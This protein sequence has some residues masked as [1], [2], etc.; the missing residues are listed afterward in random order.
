M[1]MLWFKRQQKLK[2]LTQGDIAAEFGR[3]RTI[4][5]RL[6]KGRQRFTIEHAMV[7]AK[8]L[9]QPLALILEK[10]GSPMPEAAAAIDPKLR[11]ADAEPWRPTRLADQDRLERLRNLSAPDGKSVEIW[12]VKTT[13]M[14]IAGM[15]PGDLLA[16]VEPNAIGFRSGNTVIAEAFD[17]P[18]GTTRVVLRRYDRPIL[19]PASPDQENSKCYLVDDINVRIIGLISA[20][21]RSY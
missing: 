3:D 4:V 9:D 21:F 13:A 12:I 20:S 17:G 11:F 1:D 19:A 7:F 15:L 6:Y 10:A 14:S 16:V 5:A 8:L 18:E 2:G